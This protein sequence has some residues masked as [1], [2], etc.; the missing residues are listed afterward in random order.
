M[1]DLNYSGFES[2]YFSYGKN[3][4]IVHTKKNSMLVVWVLVGS[5]WH[6]R[7]YLME[8]WSIKISIH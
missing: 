6:T 5:I 3:R 8:E 7:I 2:D 1:A 4:V